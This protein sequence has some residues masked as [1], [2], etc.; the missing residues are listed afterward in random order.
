M[1]DIG[2]PRNRTLAVG[3]WQPQFPPVVDQR[4]VAVSVALMTCDV[5]RAHSPIHLVS[6]NDG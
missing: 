4:V 5:L 1:D 6:T 2:L 3:M